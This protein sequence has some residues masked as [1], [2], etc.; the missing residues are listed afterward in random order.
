MLLASTMLDGLVGWDYDVL[1]GSGTSNS[2]YLSLGEWLASCFLIYH[3]RPL[4][5]TYLEMPQN[6]LRLVAL[7]ASQAEWRYWT[8]LV[9]L[10]CKPWLKTL[11][12]FRVSPRYL[13]CWRDS[14]ALLF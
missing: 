5:V 13:W 4:W 6:T 9:S 11:S 10:A 14:S 2:G 12:G 8:P 3:N 7:V 1:G